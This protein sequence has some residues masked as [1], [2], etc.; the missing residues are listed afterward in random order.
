MADPASSALRQADARQLVRA[1]AWPCPIGGDPDRD[2]EHGCGTGAKER[3]DLVV[4]EGE[5]GGA[6]A[7]RERRQLQPLGGDAALQ[8]GGPVA[9]CAQGLQDGLQLGAVKDGGGRIAAEVLPQAQRA[10][11]APFR[12]GAEQ[13]ELAL[14]PPVGACGQPWTACTARNC[15]S[16]VACGGTKSPGTGWVAAVIAQWSARRGIGCRA[17]RRVEPRRRITVSIVSVPAGATPT[18][19]TGCDPVA[20]WARSRLAWLR[21]ALTASA[22][23][24]SPACWAAAPR[25]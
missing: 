24:S 2:G 25:G 22:L 13:L 8:L 6:N 7:E 20:G 4:Q 19:P 15:S 3:R 5:P 17:K 12:P 11:A 23:G 16:S 14:A 1:L 18:S 21:Q 9:A 10:G